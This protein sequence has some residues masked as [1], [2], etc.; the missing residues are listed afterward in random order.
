MRSI[1]IAASA[2]ALS[3]SVFACS[4]AS[5]DTSDT[6][7]QGT[8]QDL[9][10]AK[11]N[12]IG[13]WTI[14]DKSADYSSSVAYELRPNGEFWRDDNVI[15]NGVMVNGAAPPVKRT[16][17]TWTVNASKHTI[18][19]HVET[20]AENKG[21]IETLAYTYE[22]GK[23]LNGVFLPGSEPDT[24]AHLTLTGIPAKGS[25]IAYPAVVYAQADSYCTASADCV[26][27]RDDGTWTPDQLPPG[28]GIGPVV[29]N[30][31]K[32]DEKSRTC[33][34]SVK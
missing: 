3:F 32:C 15:L 24:S 22:P 16:T 25:Q 6:Q 4:A 31:S 19:F 7:D 27:E 34:A 18:S 10:A 17:G 33:Y 21:L 30:G 8:E 5:E 11:K 13:S 29:P 2:I 12:L 9:S 14:T 1:F 20:P 28:A 26:D 23:I